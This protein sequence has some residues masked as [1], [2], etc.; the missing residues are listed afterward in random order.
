[1]VKIRVRDRLRLELG[2]RLKL[3]DIAM[4]I[5]EFADIAAINFVLEFLFFKTVELLRQTFFESF[6]CCNP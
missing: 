5:A 6:K 3:V 1:M 2:F 4:G